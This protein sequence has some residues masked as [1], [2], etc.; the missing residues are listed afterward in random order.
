[1]ENLY[2]DIGA[3]R[4]KLVPSRRGCFCNKN[5]HKERILDLLPNSLS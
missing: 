4:V 5:D 2:V 1:M 3:E